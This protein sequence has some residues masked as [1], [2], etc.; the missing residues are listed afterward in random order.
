MKKMFVFFS[1]YDWKETASSVK[2]TVHTVKES[3]HKAVQKIDFKRNRYE[4]SGGKKTR[5]HWN[6]N[7]I[8]TLKK[9]ELEE[10]YA[11]AEEQETL[12]DYVG[13][14]GIPEAFDARLWETENAALQQALTEEEYRSARATVTDAFYTDPQIAEAIWNTLQR[15]GVKKGNVLEPGLGIGNFFGVM[16]TEKDLHRYGVEVDSVSGRIAKQLYQTADISIC[17]LEKSRFHDNFFDVVVGNVPFGDFKVSDPKYDKLNL[18]IHDYFI[19]K[20]VDLVRPGGIVAVITSTGTMDKKDESFRKYLAARADLLGAV[21]LP[22]S[23]FKDMA[24]TKVSS[25]VLFLQKKEHLS[26]SDAAWISVDEVNKIRLNRYFIENPQNILGQM[27][28]D[29]RFPGHFVCVNENFS[30]LRFT[31]VLQYIKGQLTERETSCKEDIVADPDVKN[32][33]YCIRNNKVYYKENSTMRYMPFSLKDYRRIQGMD[34]IRIILHELI[35]LQA[36]PDQD[37]SR[38]QKELNQS[39]D[40]FVRN[41]GYLTSRGNKVF[42]NDADYPML[43][44]LE[45]VDPET[46]EVSKASIFTK[47]T[48]KP[49]VP[50]TRVSSAVEALNMSLNIRGC[51]DLAYMAS[52]YHTEG[53]TI[54]ESRQNIV[55]ELSGII[56]PDPEKFDPEFPEN[57][58]IDGNQY[59]SGNVRE[60]LRTAISFE[61]K[62][63]RTFTKNVEKLMEIQPK[64]VEAG[65][66]SV[67]IGAPWIDVEDYETFMYELFQTPAYAR[68]SSISESGIHINKNSLDLRYFIAEKSRDKMS[69]RATSTYG[70]KRADAYTIFENCLNLKK[71]VVKDS[72]EDD[73]GNKRYRVN[74]TETMLAEE[75]QQL[76]QDSFRNWIFKDPERRKKYVERY[77][78]LFN[79]LRLREYDGSY[80]T[81]PEMNPEIELRP[82][83]KNAV[84]RILFGGNTLL[85]HSVGAGKSFEMIAACHELKR[86]GIANK[87]MIVVPKPLVM[88]M[89]SEYIRL[90]PGADILVAT[91]YDFAK[92]RR[93]QF[94]SR[95]AMTDVDCVIMSHTQFEKIPLTVEYRRCYIE[96]KVSDIETSISMIKDQNGEHWTIKQMEGAKKRLEQ[97]LNVMLDEKRK[98][99]LIFFEELGID[100]LMVDEAHVYKNCA[101]FSKM[102]NVAGISG[103]GSQRSADMLMKCQYLESLNGRIVFSTGTPV[104]NSMCEMFVMQQY[105]QPKDL[106]NNGLQYFDAWAAT[107]GEVTTALELNVE[108]SGYRYKNRFN[109]FKNLPE[110]MNLFKKVADIKLT[111]DLDLD[112]PKLR[113][114]KY[115]IEVSEMDDYMK[116]VMETF[117]ER[118]ERIHCGCVDP[119]EDNFLKITNDAR[120]LGTDARL[121]SPDAPENPDG[122]LSKVAQNILYE[123]GRAKDL[124][125]TA[126]QLV[127]SDI[128]TPK[129]GMFNVYDCIREKLVEGG[130]PKEEVAFIHE[131]DTDASRQT[132]FQKVRSGRI[133]VLIG[134]T[135]KC[136]T[137]VNVQDHAIALHHIDC[138]WTPMRIEQREGR[139]LR[140]GNKNA[141]VAVYRYVTKGTFDAYSWSLIENKQRFISQIMTSSV[142]V[143]TCEDIDEAVMSYAEIKA[144]ATGNTLV[145]EKMSLDNDVQK[146]RL[147][148]SNFTN[149]K[150]A[151]EDAVQV[152]YP[153]L[154]ANVKKSLANTMEDIRM[155]N[156]NLTEEFSMLFD[157]VPVTERPAA[158]QFILDEM[159]KMKEG[160]KVV[161]IYQGL[162]VVVQ[163]DIL[164]S[165]LLIQ[166]KNVYHVEYSLSPTGTVTRIENFVAKL[167]EI[168]KEYESRLDS[169]ERSLKEA[170]EAIHRTFEYEEELTAKEARLKELNQMLD[171]N[172]KKADEHAA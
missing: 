160:Y 131:Y 87:P 147:L 164:G 88:Q 162:T 47:R 119:S 140:Q 74:Q 72:Y 84:A 42:R 58:W 33:T 37:I 135:D 117:V 46:K 163:K 92:E 76:I 49:A 156:E 134:S 61:K 138:P 4:K 106:E 5:F 114:G 55:Q 60:K 12:A 120:L 169:Y 102:N 149:Q 130:I 81:F 77:N 103:S 168:Q 172:A 107:F 170:K 104:S 139:I 136:G 75:K 53:E 143:R 122:K 67:Q 9:V 16:E 6:L 165:K 71:T 91:E 150:Y 7:A 151:M 141:E 94:I 68:Y 125:M 70:T 145:K 24:G 95:I 86:L 56:F 148:K 105:L 126:T 96:Q 43:C 34:Q 121:L 82:H 44:A 63:P 154:I 3:L 10:R 13:W 21:R 99:D 108:G 155:R 32:F 89:A 90:Y 36:V 66:I 62:Y 83:Q 11:T 129:P 166:G 124:G 132:L 73:N 38:K 50:V 128:G 116:A 144:V 57:G 54:K 40:H 127:F 8:K 123:Y 52:I 25:D 2:E 51:V 78:E 118:A 113:G 110:L 18:R 30:I 153:K 17:G 14:G 142:S 111:K 97:Q 41:Y 39:Y 100:C 79:N 26:E 137:G 31:D 80:L 152:K 93:Q 29:T 35:R 23:A 22:D 15:M 171:L 45:V 112:I 19:A 1:T 159:G 27:K 85:A 115:I 133:K 161:C 28:E 69:L 101:C 64:D 109:R 65:D 59:L 158:G 157:G 98:D 20:S 167:E 48:V 146:L